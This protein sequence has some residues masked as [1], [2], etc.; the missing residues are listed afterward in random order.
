MNKTLDE[1]C[2][3]LI[4]HTTLNYE[5]TDIGIKIIF[6]KDLETLVKNWQDNQ[7]LNIEKEIVKVQFHELK[8]LQKILLDYFNFRK[9]KFSEM[10]V[11]KDNA[12]IYDEITINNKFPETNTLLREF[13]LFNKFIKD[14]YERKY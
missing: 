12:F 4:N 5:P 2:K 13:E 6:S 10:L 14:E 8:V 9:P 1:T 3:L 7:D 11:L